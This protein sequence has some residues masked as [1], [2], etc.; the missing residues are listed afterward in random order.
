[1][2]RLSALSEYLLI[3]IFFGLLWLP[4]I[5]T[6][7]S[8]EFGQVEVEEKRVLAEMPKL[9]SEP[10][11]DLPQKFEDYFQDH[12]AFRRSLIRANTWITYSFLHVRPREVYV[13]KKGW[14]FYCSHGIGEDMMGIDPLTSEDLARIAASLQERQDWLS[15]RGIKYLLVIPPSKAS[16]YPEL[17]PDDVAG[18]LGTTRL[19]QLRAYLKE[20]STV[21]FLDLRP[22]LVA[23]KSRKELY[24]PHD[25]HWS[26]WG[27]FYAYQAIINRL[28][29]WF[30]DLKPIDETEVDVGSYTWNGDLANMLALGPQE[31]NRDFQ[32]PVPRGNPKAVDANL[33]MPPDLDWPEQ[34]DWQKPRAKEN[35]SAR[36]RLLIFHDSFTIAGLDTWLPENFRRTVLIFCRSDRE[37]LRMLVEQEKPD[38]VIEEVLERFLIRPVFDPYLVRVWGAPREKT[39]K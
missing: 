30:P 36:L 21:N 24:L 9:G 6:P 39:Q 4:L 35:P 18:R 22:V 10:L 14:L 32:G 1:M 7:F 34:P 20:H 25:S 27:A 2:S 11:K 8:W 3:A 19:D 31:V 33:E 37:S 16:V 26:H 28:S 5:G 17:L 38:V 13:G 15:E 29:E 23:A 12:F